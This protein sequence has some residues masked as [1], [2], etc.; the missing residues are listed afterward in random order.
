MINEYRLLITATFTDPG[1]RSNAY[2]AMKTQIQNYAT[3]HPGVLKRA[4]MKEDDYMIAEGGRS[5]KVIQLALTYFGYNNSS[6]Q[7]S[8][9][10]D[11]QWYRNRNY[12]D[13]FVCPG[14][15]HQAVKEI[16][17]Y[18]SMPSGSGN[19]RCAVFDTSGNL[20][21]QGTAEV[22]VTGTDPAWHGHLTQANITPNP[23]NLTGGVQYDIALAWDSA[24]MQFYFDNA[25]AGDGTYA[26][27]DY[28]GGFPASLADATQTDVILCIRCGVEAAAVGLS[29]LIAHNLSGDCNRMQGMD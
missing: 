28:T 23:C 21:S 13:G 12:I 5:E 25:S 8:W 18:V 27:T 20:I 4:D 29:L 14:S 19:I 22:A 26:Y 1:A 2:D 15:G 3:S 9:K 16:S 17:A 10:D 6:P 7:Y 24:S 11:A